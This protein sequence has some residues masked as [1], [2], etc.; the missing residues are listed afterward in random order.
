MAGRWMDIMGDELWHVNNAFLVP[1][2][3]LDFL[4]SEGHSFRISLTLQRLLL[5]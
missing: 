4:R 3:I 1:N 5:K 2:K